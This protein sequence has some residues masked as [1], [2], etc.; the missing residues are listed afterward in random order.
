M[1][2]VGSEP[3]MA[4]VFLAREPEEVVDAFFQLSWRDGYGEAGRGASFSAGAQGPEGRQKVVSRSAAGRWNPNGL[5]QGKKA[6]SA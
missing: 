5:R 6:A 4:V 2:P 3:T 1:K